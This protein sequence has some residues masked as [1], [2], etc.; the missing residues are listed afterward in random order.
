[1]SQK[2]IT[3]VLVVVLASAVVAGVTVARSRR[4]TAGAPPPYRDVDPAQL[5]A[6]LGRKDFQLV[7][8]HVP[9]EGEIDGTDASIPHT[10]IAAEALARLGY[11][12]VMNLQ[13]GMRA[14]Q[15]AGYPLVRR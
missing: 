1:V 10:D 13:G 3:G 11:R 5:R 14:W 9:Y 4:L 8:V 2:V 7:N 15:R 12:N 6:M